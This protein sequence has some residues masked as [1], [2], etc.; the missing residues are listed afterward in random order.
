MYLY[1]VT[2]NPTTAVNQAIHGNFSGT[3]QQEIVVAKQTRIELL[4]PDPTSGKVHT[5]LSHECFGLIRTLAP[6]RLTGGNKG[7]H[8]ISLC[9][10]PTH[11][12]LDFI[13]V[14]SDSGRIV[15]LEYNSAKNTFD[16]V[17]QETY[18]K[19]GVRRI[20]PGQYLAADPKGRAVMIGAVEKQKL[21]YIL[22]R[23]SAANLTI[24]SP[25][26]AHKSHTINHH[27]VAVD[28]GFENPVFA[29]LEVEYTDADQD[30]TGAAAEESE[31]ML[32]YYELDLGLNHVV[33]KWTEVVDRKANMLVPGK[34]YILVVCWAIYTD[35]FCSSWW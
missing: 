19:T 35:N 22:N 21:V 8:L 10:I 6:F 12:L 11:V 24:S 16:K 5:V 13:I 3:R 17:H 34:L 2:I 32:T 26:E 7:K 18:G 9:R 15:I 27:L 33:K 28:V 29:C 30:P 1:N 31:K 14:G 25:L 23:D 20:V 4:R